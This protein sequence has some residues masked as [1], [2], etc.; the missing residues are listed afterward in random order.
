[1]VS[2]FNYLVPCCMYEST[3]Y[4]MFNAKHEIDKYID[5]VIRH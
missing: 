4:T 3:L 5:E 1:M 2:T